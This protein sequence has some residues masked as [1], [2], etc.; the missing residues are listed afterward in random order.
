M[1]RRVRRRFQAK[2]ARHLA[3]DLT[4]QCVASGRVEGEEFVDRQQLHKARLLG[5]ESG[6]LL[7]EKAADLLRRRSDPRDIFEPQPLAQLVERLG[8]AAGERGGLNWPS[9]LAEHRLMVWRPRGAQRFDDGVNQ[10][11][12]MASIGQ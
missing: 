5:P 2:G 12:V 9:R 1:G 7:V 11:T 6:D 4:G 3:R 8:G 10:R